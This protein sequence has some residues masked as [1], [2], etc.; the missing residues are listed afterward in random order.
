MSQEF[1]REVR[2]GAVDP[3]PDKHEA[4]L[5][6]SIDSS[7]ATANRPARLTVT[8]ANT[9]ETARVFS[10]VFE[11][12]ASSSHGR[13]G[14][15]LV[16]GEGRWPPRCVETEGNGKSQDALEFAGPDRSVRLSAGER[17]KEE[18]HV[19]DDPTVEGCIPP[20][21][22]PYESLYAIDPSANPENAPTFTWGFELEVS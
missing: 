16:P 1:R 3:H 13:P 7:A 5:S 18:F 15:L 9:A 21:D 12:Y 8:L 11:G 4:E 10:T 20:G 19:T 14:I 2:I 17:A 22:Y 6:V